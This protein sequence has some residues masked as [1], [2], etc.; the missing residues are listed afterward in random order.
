[1]NTTPKSAYALPIAYDVLLTAG[2]PL[3]LAYFIFCGFTG[4]YLPH[5]LLLA[6]FF[7]F[8]LLYLMASFTL[9]VLNIAQSFRKYAQGADVYCLNAMLVLKYGLVIY[10]VL[11]FVV[12]AFFVLLVVAASRG[13]ILFAVPLYPAIG[14]IFFLI[15]GGTW[16]G[17]LPGAF[18]GLHTVRF[19]RAQGKLS[20]KAAILHSI[21]QFIFL[22]D[23]L[24]ALYLSVKLWGRGKKSAIVV[25]I[26]YV[27]PAAL[28]LCLRL[29]PIFS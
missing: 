8:V 25:G 12:Y 18:Y 21:L 14:A 13:T 29:R 15:I 6:G 17:L 11:N 2:F 1:M 4:R 7:V 5:Q 26:L 3:A 23:V 9:G 19:A 20:S 28:F 10:F 24:D 22:L 27:V 16:V